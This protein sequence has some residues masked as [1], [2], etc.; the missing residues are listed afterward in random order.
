MARG[1]L[2]PD[3]A[4]PQD[5]VLR[6]DGESLGEVQFRRLIHARMPQGN[7]VRHVGR[8]RDVDRLSSPPRVSDIAPLGPVAVLVGP[9]A[10]QCAPIQVVVKVRLRGIQPVLECRA[11]QVLVVVLVAVGSTYVVRQAYQINRVGEGDT[12]ADLLAHRESPLR[13]DEIVRIDG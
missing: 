10:R 1:S 8:A 6:G 9:L 7:G 4:D 2:G 13:V 5:T 3:G 11:A 12:V